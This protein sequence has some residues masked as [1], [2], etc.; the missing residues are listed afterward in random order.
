MKMSFR[1]A[2]VVLAAGVLLLVLLTVALAAAGL[3]RLVRHNATVRTGGRVLRE[4]VSDAYFSLKTGDLILFVSVSFVPSSTI[5]THAFFSHVGMVVE[6]PETLCISEAQGGDALMPDPR[7]PGREV[8]MGWGAVLVPFLV[9]VK[10]YAGLVYVSR[11]ARRLGPESAG[12]LCAAAE[13][14]ASSVYPYPTVSQILLGFVG[15]QQAARHCFQHVAHLIDAA[16]L[17]PAGRGGPLTE[18][19]FIEVC[20]EVCGL[21]GRPLP[22]NT[23]GAPVQLLYD[24]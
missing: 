24:V 20:H 16:G 5:L 18:A 6:T 19:G 22:G 4:K 12:R 15:R 13:E 8:R 7:C 10:N 2:A 17:T 1:E 14:A 21:P 11:L 23:Y 3:C 9:R